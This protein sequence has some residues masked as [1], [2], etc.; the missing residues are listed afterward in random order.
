VHWGH[1]CRPFLLVA[2]PFAGIR[3]A[4]VIVLGLI[5]PLLGLS[6]IAVL[7]IQQVLFRQ[8]VVV[9]DALGLD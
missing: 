1:A 7:V 2:R 4:I 5:V 6:L 9:R 8:V 3:I